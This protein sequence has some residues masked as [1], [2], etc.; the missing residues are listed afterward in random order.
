MSDTKDNFCE[1]V[2]IEDFL[3]YDYKTRGMRINYTK[4]GIE[5]MEKEIEFAIKYDYVIKIACDCG[6]D[7]VGAIHLC[8]GMSKDEK[9][10][11]D[12]WSEDRLKEKFE[13]MNRLYQIFRKK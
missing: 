12:K 10:F 1:D 2:T 4:V 11:P 9:G 5:K 8:Y 6:F 13:G 7:K 3:E